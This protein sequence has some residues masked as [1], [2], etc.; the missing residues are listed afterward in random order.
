MN[1]WNDLKNLN[2]K[3]NP[4]DKCMVFGYCNGKHAYSRNI[5]GSTKY[6]CDS[7]ICSAAV[8]SGAINKDSSGFFKMI[9]CTN[10]ND[11]GTVFGSST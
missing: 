10:L 1:N 11:M 9:L 5:W 2:K 8:H 7:N 6:T 4:N 3:L